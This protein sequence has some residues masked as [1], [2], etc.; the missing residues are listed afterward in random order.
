MDSG[1]SRDG[2]NGFSISD[3]PLNYREALRHGKEYFTTP[4]DVSSMHLLNFFLC[5]KNS[6]F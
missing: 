5:H 4:R 2:F 6:I 3:I 1:R